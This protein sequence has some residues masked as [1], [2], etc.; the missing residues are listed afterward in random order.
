M[1]TSLETELSIIT[2]CEEVGHLDLH[3]GACRR[4]LMPTEE[5]RIIHNYLARSAGLS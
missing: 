5:R 2:Y 1:F 3:R 4:C